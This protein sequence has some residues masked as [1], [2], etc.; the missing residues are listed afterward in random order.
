M[1]REVR[2][3]WLVVVVGKGGRRR[4]D[5]RKGTRLRHSGDVCGVERMSKGTC[6]VS[7][8]F[9]PEATCTWVGVA[10]GGGHGKVEQKGISWQITKLEYSQKPIFAHLALLL[11]NFSG[12]SG[13]H[14]ARLSCNAN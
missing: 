12:P 4:R 3:E 8:V 9:R 10:F 6:R 14:A 1:A 7:V 2:G 13:F 11:L 5:G